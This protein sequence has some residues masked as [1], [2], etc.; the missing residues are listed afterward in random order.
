MLSNPE[1][2]LQLLITK[3]MVDDKYKEALSSADRLYQIKSFKI[4]DLRPQQVFL[5]HYLMASK[6]L[7]GYLDFTRHNT[8]ILKHGIKT[9][10]NFLYG[11]SSVISLN[12]NVVLT[13]WY[14]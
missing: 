3:M 4:L 1:G 9:N 6:L 10:S 8:E 5:M 13:K 2:N 12:K 7:F 11:Y 14:R